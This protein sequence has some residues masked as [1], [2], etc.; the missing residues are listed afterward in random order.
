MMKRM[1][2]EVCR[3]AGATS[4][5]LS[6]CTAAHRVEVANG[7][8]PRP[9]LLS[10]SA[11]RSPPRSTG[12]SLPARSARYSILAVLLLTRACTSSMLREQRLRL[13]DM[14]LIMLDDEMLDEDSQRLG[15]ILYV[16]SHLLQVV[17]AHLLEQMDHLLIA[18]G[19]LLGNE[20]ARCMT[21]LRN[22]LKPGG[23]VQAAPDAGS[24][25]CQNLAYLTGKEL[26]R[27][28]DMHEIFGQRP[29]LCNETPVEGGII[30]LVEEGEQGLLALMQICQHFGLRWV[31]SHGSPRRRKLCVVARSPLQRLVE[32]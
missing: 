14:G 2:C 30:D 31:F 21:V 1:A 18:V 3:C 19:Q 26:A 8:P 12:T 32:R 23:V 6:H 13:L 9:G 10:P 29:F 28:G 7:S 22:I 5:P 4:R 11:L 20:R 24:R 27:F 17:L 15:A 25:R 16:R